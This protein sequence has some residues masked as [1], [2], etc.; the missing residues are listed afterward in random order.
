MISPDKRAK[1]E[2]R[3]VRRLNVF[4]NFQSVS[5]TTKSMSCIGCVYSVNVCELV[6]IK[7]S[8]LHVIYSF[9]LFVSFLCHFVATKEFH[10]HKTR[11]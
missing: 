7:L 10:Y 3:I 11:L 2:L 9:S 5:L 1:P 8:F 6:K 4:K